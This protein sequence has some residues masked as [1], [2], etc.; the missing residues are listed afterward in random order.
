[1]VGKDSV[2]VFNKAII[3]SFSV[4]KGMVKK[5]NDLFYQIMYDGSKITLLKKHKVNIVEGIFNSIDGA[6]K[7][8]RF[9]TIDDFI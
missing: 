9:K 1:M 5:Y 4:N 3:D 7:K 6:K 2:L 8:S